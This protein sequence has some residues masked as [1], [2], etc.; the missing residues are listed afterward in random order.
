MNPKAVKVIVAVVTA[1]VASALMQNL[2]GAME[3]NQWVVAI[4]T[5]AAPVLI[6][7]FVAGFVTKGAR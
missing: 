5:I 6:G 1:V 3:L 4:L 7:G 2:I